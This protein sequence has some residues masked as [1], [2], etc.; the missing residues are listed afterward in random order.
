MK[1]IKIISEDI[2]KELDYAEDC[3]KKAVQYKT[4]FPDV[5]R[6]YDSL[7]T[8]HLNCAKNLHDQVVSIINKYKS[9]KGE[10][11]APMMAIY[12][13]LHERQINK[14][15]GVRNLQEIFKQMM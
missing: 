11:P 7:C 1:I 13:Y 10:P 14:T 4:E 9:E 2:E 12:E 5:A 6:V 8:A 3:I 15:I